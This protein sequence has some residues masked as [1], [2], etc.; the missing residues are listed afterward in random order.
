MDKYAV[1]Q[2][3]VSTTV[4]CAAFRVSQSCWRCEPKQNAYVERCN[5][6][7]HY[8]WLS[9]HDWSRIEEVREFATRWMWSYNHERPHRALGGLTPKQ[10]LARAA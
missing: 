2:R 4:A 5:R 7:V 10:H 8:E 6:R 1:Q 9:Q 3:S